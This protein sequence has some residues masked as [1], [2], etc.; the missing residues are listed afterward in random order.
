MSYRKLQAIMRCNKCKQIAEGEIYSELTVN[1]DWKTDRLIFENEL[2]F[3][4][5]EQCDNTGFVLYPVKVIDKES[6][7]EACIIPVVETLNLSEDEETE[8]MGFAVLEVTD[9]KPL[10]IFYSL[11]DLQEQVHN[12]GG[13]NETVFDPP[14]QE[15]DIEEGLKKKLISEQEAAILRN[16]NWDDILCDLAV[17]VGDKDN[18]NDCEIELGDEKDE[19]LDVYFKLMEALIQKRKVIYL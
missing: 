6:G 17:Q 15:Q 8:G 16:A 18:Y 5:C 7:E 11:S 9:K 13:G 1:E 4:K 10:S 3:Y 12:W 2:N 14:P 19:A